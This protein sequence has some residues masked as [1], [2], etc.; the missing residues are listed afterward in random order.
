MQLR[1]LLLAG[2]LRELLGRED[3]NLRNGNQNPVSC[4]WTTPQSSRDSTISRV[5]AK[6]K[7]SAGIGPSGCAAA[8]FGQILL[9]EG[10]SLQLQTVRFENLS[11]DPA[12]G[13]IVDRMR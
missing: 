2:S 13:R 3:S 9:D 11:F 1:T 4:H 10:T 5:P 6:L 8:G 7:K 12:S